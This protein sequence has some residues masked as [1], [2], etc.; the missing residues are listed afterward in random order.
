MVSVTDYGKNV[1][2]NFVAPNNA[3][4]GNNWLPIYSKPAYS[5]VEIQSMVTNLD[6]VMT[7]L[8]FAALIEETNV[9]AAPY[10]GPDHDDYEQTVTVKATVRESSREADAKTI[11]CLRIN[12]GNAL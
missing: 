8:P 5:G 6:L 10:I 12:G 9:S 7:P 2:A 4:A 11:F 3:Y 1:W